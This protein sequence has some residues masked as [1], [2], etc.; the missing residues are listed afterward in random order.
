LKLKNEAK[1][2]IVNED[3]ERAFLVDHLTDSVASDNKSNRFFKYA[4]IKGQSKSFNIFECSQEF[5]NLFLPEMSLT[6]L[7]FKFNQPLEAVVVSLVKRLLQV[8][9]N[10]INQKLDKPL[11]LLAFLNNFFYFAK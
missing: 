11:S 5:S 9:T 7:T 8:I 1:I 4:K 10:V 2:V 3:N 6:V